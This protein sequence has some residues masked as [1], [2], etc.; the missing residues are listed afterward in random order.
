LSEKGIGMK[1]SR[2][3]ESLLAEGL[4]WR[5]KETWFGA[6]VDPDFER[7]RGYRAP[8]HRSTRQQYCRLS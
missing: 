4:K 7:E 5:Q 1:R 8:L 2:I 6:R 3:S